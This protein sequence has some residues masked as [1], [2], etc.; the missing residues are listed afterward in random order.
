MKR[1]IIKIGTKLLST[2]DNQL[3]THSLKHM[4]SQI[5]SLKKDSDFDVIVVTSG[6]IVFG[7]EEMGITA[8]SIPEKQAAAAVGQ[9][10]LLKQYHDFFEQEGI[11]IG[12]LLLTQDIPEHSIKK[13]NVI[14]TVNTLLGQNVIPIINENDTV[15]TEEIKFGDNDILASIVAILLDADLLILLTDQDGLYD[16][17]PNK[18]TDAKLITEINEVTEAMIN[19]SDSDIDAKG[20]GGIKSKLLAARKMLAHNKL[21][22]IANGRQKNV[23]TDIMNGLPVGSHFIKRS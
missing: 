21:M 10:A 6:A 18:H 1:I 5:A 12:Q 23:I 11:K 22:V 7:S 3:D 20:Q 16:K 9:L 2:V 8:T 14:N 15:S 19:A 17:N 4:V 13:E